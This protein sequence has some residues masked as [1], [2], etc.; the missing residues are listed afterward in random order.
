MTNLDKWRKFLDKQGWKY[1]EVNTD[2]GSRLMVKIYNKTHRCHIF[3]KETGLNYV[4]YKSYMSKTTK[5]MIRGREFKI[6]LGVRAGV[7]HMYSHNTVRGLRNLGIKGPETLYDLFRCYS[8]YS[9]FK[10]NEETIHKSKSMIKK[11]KMILIFFL[12]VNKIKHQ[13]NSVKEVLK[14]ACYPG[15]MCFPKNAI[16]PLS[17][18]YRNPEFTFHDIYKKIFKHKSKL[19]IKNLVKYTPYQVM[20]AYILRT[21]FNRG[22]LEQLLNVT[23]DY[24][25]VKYNYNRSM[26][27]MSNIKIYKEFFKLFTNQQLLKLFSKEFNTY[28]IVDTIVPWM[29]RKDKII[30]KSKYKN[31][32]EVHDDVNKQYRRLRNENYNFNIKPKLSK[33]HGVKIDKETIVVPQNRH[34]LIDWGTLMNNCIASYHSQFHQGY[35]TILG[36]KED[37]KIKYNIEIR[38]GHIVQFVLNRNQ[39]ADIET[40]TKFKKVFKEYNLIGGQ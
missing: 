35:T 20:I 25:T 14:T 34:E 7:L 3:I 26:G 8:Q 12:K 40:I 30:L 16:G 27:E 23:S 2:Y 9:S 15:L 13:G 5:G 21:R 10:N 1:K 11:L 6:A 17:F 29:E 22:E 28:H 38:N 33:I 24:Q 37:D 39:R 31:W 19:I 4:F 36:I 32:R 18:L